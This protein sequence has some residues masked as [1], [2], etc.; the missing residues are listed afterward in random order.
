[1]Y[2]GITRGGTMRRYVMIPL[3]AAV[4]FAA[5]AVLI[6]VQPLARSAEA[7]PAGGVTDVRFGD[8]ITYERAVL[9]FDASP[10]GEPPRYSWRYREGDTVIRV[11]LPETQA[12]ALTGGN[13]LGRAFSHYQ[14]VRKDGGWLYV[15]LFLNSAARNVNVFSLDDPG[16]IVVDVTPGAVQLSPTPVHE[17]GVYVMSP[18]PGSAAGPGEMMVH[19]YARPFEATGVWR[20]KD[21]GGQIVRRGTYTTADWASTWGAYSF[22]V[23]YPASLSGQSGTLEIGSASARDGSFTGASVPLY[24]R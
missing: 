15:D 8:H 20:V 2:L 5:S 19:G 22:W 4:L 16:R 17:N 10:T 1:M 21:A 23:D 7:A 11:R 24:F 18:R 14:V 12:T 6:S 13:G 9:D 3:I